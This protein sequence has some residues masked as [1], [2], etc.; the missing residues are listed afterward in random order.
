[1][2]R[3][4]TAAAHETCRKCGGEEEEYVA[5]GQLAKVMCSSA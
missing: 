3:H 1:M 2:R 5:I 4:A